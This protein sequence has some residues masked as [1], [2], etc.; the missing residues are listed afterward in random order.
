MAVAAH[1]ADPIGAGPACVG[2]LTLPLRQR[3]HRPRPRQLA[4]PDQGPH[5][6]DRRL[7]ERMLVWDDLNPSSGSPSTTV[8]STGTSRPTGDDRR[9]ALVSYRMGDM[10]APGPAE[11]EALGG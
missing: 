9:E 3:R 8:A 2:Y 5:D 4:Q 1:G 6:D 11:G 7:R 10:V